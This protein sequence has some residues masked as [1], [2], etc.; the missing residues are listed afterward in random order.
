MTGDLRQVLSQDFEEN[1]PGRGS[2]EPRLS[3]TI[4]GAKLV[5]IESSSSG[6]KPGDTFAAGRETLIGRDSRSDIRIAGSFV[7]ARHARIYSRE[8][9]YWLEDL[10]ST[11]GTF[12]NGIQVNQ[13]I[14]LAGGDRIK[15]GGV[16]FQFVRWGYEVDAG[17]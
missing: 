1:R 10:N 9:Q 14:V 16:T 11:N 5:V 8:G 3:G 13:P 12:L 15:I 17:N 6:L 2:E 4:D 7:S